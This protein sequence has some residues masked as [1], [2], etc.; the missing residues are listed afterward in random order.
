LHQF[1]PRFHYFVNFSTG[2]INNSTP[3]SRNSK[4][5]YTFNFIL[6]LESFLGDLGSLSNIGTDGVLGI[7][8]GP[9]IVL[10]NKYGFRLVPKVVE[11]ILKRNIILNLGKLVYFIKGMIDLELIIS[12][13]NFLR[14]YKRIK[15]VRKLQSA[16]PKFEA[17]P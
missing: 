17:L 16:Q 8:D 10:K 12:D 14:L 7:N 2:L 4:P 3:P 5:F 1:A 9:R 15:I 6:I 11:K 13:I